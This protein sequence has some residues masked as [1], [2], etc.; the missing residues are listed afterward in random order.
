MLKVF[1]L[2]SLKMA[3]T[4]KMDIL[5]IKLKFMKVILIKVLKMA[6]ENLQMPFISISVI[7][8]KIFILVK[9]NL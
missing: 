1:S 5:L 2:V 7:F 3:N 9:V 8:N 4:L 6:M